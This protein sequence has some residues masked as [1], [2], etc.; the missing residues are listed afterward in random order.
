MTTNNKI[1]R[2][3]FVAAVM[4]FVMWIIS[5]ALLALVFYAGSRGL[6]ALFAWSDPHGTKPPGPFWETYVTCFL[7]GLFLE[8]SFFTPA[9]AFYQWRTQPSWWRAF[10]ASLFAHRGYST[11]S[12]FIFMRN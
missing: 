11:G 12:K 2:G 10:I 6:T 1:D 5:A 8:F 7:V 9:N 4:G 3:V